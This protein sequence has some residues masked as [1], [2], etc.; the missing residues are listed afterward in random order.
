MVLPPRMPVTTATYRASSVSSTRQNSACPGKSRPRSNLMGRGGLVGGSRR[1]AIQDLEGELW[2]IDGVLVGGL[3]DALLVLLWPEPLDGED[4]GRHV[5]TRAV[6]GR[7][8]VEFQLVYA[9]LGGMFS[10]F[11]EP[12]VVGEPAFNDKQRHAH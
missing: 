8:Q 12:E 3:H 4:P 5:P 7:L 11:P 2:L 10:V 6:G 1:F 9:G